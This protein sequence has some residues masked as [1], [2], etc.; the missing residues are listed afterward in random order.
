[1]W[2]KVRE[3]SCCH[4]SSVL[5][6]LPLPGFC[7]TNTNRLYDREVENILDLKQ[8]QK[9]GTVILVVGEP[10]IIYCDTLQQNLPFCV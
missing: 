8:S 10:K 7:E 9:H 6:V 1:M 3:Q 2:G 4:Y 5:W